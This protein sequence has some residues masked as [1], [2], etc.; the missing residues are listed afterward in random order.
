[1]C[2]YGEGREAAYDIN[3]TTNIDIILTVAPQLD[4]MENRVAVFCTV[5]GH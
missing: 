4:M 2:V 3:T 1:M 5:C